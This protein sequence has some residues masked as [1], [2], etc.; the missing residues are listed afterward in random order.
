MENRQIQCPGCGAAVSLSGAV[1]KYCSA[2]L[3]TDRV[4][5]PE[6]LE[7]LRGVVSAMED[8][9]KS[10]ENDSRIA[11][12]SFIGF[13]AFG[14]ALYFF[15]SWY[16]PTGW[17]AIVLSVFTAAVLFCAFGFVVS[18]TNRR[19]WIRIYNGDLKLRIDEYLR[20]MK[21]SRYEFDHEADRILPKNAR[22]RAFLYKP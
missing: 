19:L 10:A 1:C 9:L 20:L 15:Y 18:I 22:L 4:L 7:K 16:F 21:F 13:A 17:K 5:P 8:S 3:R 6:D 11:G 2:P 14:I 12:F